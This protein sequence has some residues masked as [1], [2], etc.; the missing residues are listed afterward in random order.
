ML[1]RRHCRHLDSRSGILYSLEV[2]N[3][4]GDQGR[5]S[6][7]MCSWTGDLLFYPVWGCTHLMVKP[8]WRDCNVNGMPKSSDF[9][10]ASFV[11][12]HCHLPSVEMEEFNDNI[13]RWYERDV[14]LGVARMLWRQEAFTRCGS[15]YSPGTKSEGQFRPELLVD[16]SNSY[17]YCTCRVICLHKRGNL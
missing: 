4:D 10:F 14:I 6:P 11:S 1:S 2:N 9:C 8:S 17:P 3:D 15:V 16:H 12:M 13:D 5:V 7:Q